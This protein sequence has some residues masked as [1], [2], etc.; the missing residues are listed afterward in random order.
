MLQGGREALCQWQSAVAVTDACAPVGVA[1]RSGCVA[2]F[3]PLN[4]LHRFVTVR[5]A[6]SEKEAQYTTCSFSLMW[7]KVP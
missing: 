2:D 1:A 6:N 5:G 3:K 7:N 4:E